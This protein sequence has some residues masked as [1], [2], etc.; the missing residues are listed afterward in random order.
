MCVYINKD[1]I[2]CICTMLLG[3]LARKTMYNFCVWEKNL[4]ESPS[5]C[6]F[7]IVC[8]HVETMCPS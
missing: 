7:N 5:F 4:F 2:N 3:M 1:M 8:H 6:K